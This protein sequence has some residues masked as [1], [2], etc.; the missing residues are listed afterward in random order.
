MFKPVLVRVPFSYDADGVSEDTGLMCVDETL[1]TQADKEEVD[2]NT[3]VRRFGIGGEMPQDVRIPLSAD[4]VERLDYK[5]ALNLIR[6]AE[7]GF[8]QMPADVRARFH[9]DPAELV[10]F[11][12]DVENAPEARK[13][14]I[15]V[16]EPEVRKPEEPMLV[17]IAPEE[18]VKPA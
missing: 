11:V 8:M 5:D 17:R 16:P 14:G 6:E 13:L 3:L 15:L 12:S 7:M 1:A 9:H 18:P 2:I 10:A 4:F